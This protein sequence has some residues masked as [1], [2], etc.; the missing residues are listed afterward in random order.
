MSRARRFGQLTIDGDARCVTLDG[1]P[2]QLTRTEFD[3]LVTLADRAG[4]AISN[5]ELLEA[6]W[7]CEWRIDTTPLQVHVSRLRNKLGESGSKPHHIVTVR[8]FGY[9]FDPNPMG[10]YQ[11]SSLLEGHEVTEVVLR[12]DH[13]LLL[14]EL[15][16]P[17]MVLGWDPQD[18]IGTYFAP[19]GVDRTSVLA[20]L[21]HLGSIP[22]TGLSG[23]FQV[24]ARDGSMA[25]V[26]ASI[27]VDW[28]EHGDLDGLHCRW[29]LPVN[30]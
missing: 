13:N 15:Q 29:L 2:V 27:I 12:Y 7:D 17:V 24:V 18:I 26:Q 1:A 19:A 21:Q 6:M 30:G 9:R 8:G 28:D 23:Q 3:L 4:A 16:P 25:P 10:D 11:G 22:V 5:R 20:F 14:R